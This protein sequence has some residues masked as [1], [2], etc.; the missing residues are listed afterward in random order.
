METF[1]ESL[2]P[3][4][5]IC[6]VEER[7]GQCWHLRRE[8]Q[9]LFEMVG[10]QRPGRCRRNMEG[11]GRGVNRQREAGPRSPRGRNREAAQQ[12]STSSPGQLPAQNGQGPAVCG[13]TM[14]GPPK[15]PYARKETLL[16]SWANGKHKRSTTEVSCVPQAPDVR[17][18]SGP[19]RT[20]KAS[21][22]GFDHC[23]YVLAS[24]AYGNAFRSR[25]PSFSATISSCLHKSE[26]V[27]TQRG[28]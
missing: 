16:P 19:F 25:L 10:P 27:S 9:V 2:N 3:H 8:S 26:V 18:R 13:R 4:E 6:K 7:K 22:N 24:T 5:L 20:A 28:R 23:K 1:L 21:L 17:L 12:P 11:E 15:H 14:A